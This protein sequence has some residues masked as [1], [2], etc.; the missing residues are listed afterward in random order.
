MQNMQE[1]EVSFSFQRRKLS[2]L[3]QELQHLIGI[4]FVHERPEDQKVQSE[5]YRK[6]VAG[7]TYTQDEDIYIFFVDQDHFTMNRFKELDVSERNEVIQKIGSFMVGI[8]DSI[9]HIRDSRDKEVHGKL[10]VVQIKEIACLRMKEVS[11]LI[12]S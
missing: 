4:H 3:E 12:R 9:K 8:T 2:K 11:E 10:L 6:R 7:W 1:H 5:I